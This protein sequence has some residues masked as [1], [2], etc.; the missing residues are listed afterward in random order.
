MLEQIIKGNLNV[1][2]LRALFRDI[3]DDTSTLLS[4]DISDG[5][6][7]SKEG[8]WRTGFLVQP[9]DDSG[10]GSLRVIRNFASF[11]VSNSE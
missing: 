3:C 1:Q 5:F 9:L 2:D 6:G 7:G 4:G 10:G 8:G 11:S